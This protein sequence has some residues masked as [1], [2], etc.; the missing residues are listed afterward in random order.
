MVYYM[1]NEELEKMTTD[2]LRENDSEY[3]HKTG[4]KSNMMEYPY[5]SEGQ[6]KHINSNEIPLSNLTNNQ[7]L[8]CPKFGDAHTFEEGI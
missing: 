7:R 2:F 5:H 8:Q 3:F 6:Q 4:P 1:T